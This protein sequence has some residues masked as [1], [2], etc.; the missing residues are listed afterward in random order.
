MRDKFD[1]DELDHDKFDHIAHFLERNSQQS[2]FQ[3]LR[4]HTVNRRK[5]RLGDARSDVPQAGHIVC[6]IGGHIALDV[7]GQFKQGRPCLSIARSR[8]SDHL[9]QS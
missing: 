1:H 6:V 7:H 8:R 3:T 9:G 5:R 4:N 2:T